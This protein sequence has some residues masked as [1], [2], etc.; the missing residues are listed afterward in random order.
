MS[1]KGILKRCERNKTD[2]KVF[3]ML[4]RH[5]KK[6]VKEYFKIIDRDDVTEQVFKDITIYLESINIDSTTSHSRINIKR[7]VAY[8]ECAIKHELLKEPEL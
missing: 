7:T 8:E 1:A 2:E 4:D 5:M 3:K 6:I